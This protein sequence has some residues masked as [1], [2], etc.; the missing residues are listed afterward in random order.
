MS[1]KSLTH[2]DVTKNELYN[3]LTEVTEKLKNYKGRE[4]IRVRVSGC[5]MG[6]VGRR[7][8]RQ[9]GSKWS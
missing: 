2:L 9:S 6:M 5:G 8:A 3:S 4:A 1:N 7:Q